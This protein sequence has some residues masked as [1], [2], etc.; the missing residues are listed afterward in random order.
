MPLIASALFI[1]VQTS[2][3][4]AACPASAVDLA[5]L[6]INIPCVLYEGLPYTCVMHAASGI[7]GAELAW[8]LDP[9]LVKPSACAA[10]TASCA[11]ISNTLGLTLKQMN[12]GGTAYILE[13]VYTRH[14]DDP[15]GL[16]WKYLSHQPVSGTQAINLRVSYY[17]TY[18]NTL[19]K[20]AQIEAN[21]RHLS[22][23]IYEA[24]NGVHRLGKITVFS[25][26]G[27]ADDTDILWLKDIN[28][29][30]QP[31]WFNSQLGGYGIKGQR[32]QH[33]DIGANN[34]SRYD[35]LKAPRAGG[36]TL[37][38]EWGH[39]FYGLYDE[40][41][42]QSFCSS[43][44]PFA[45]CSGDTPA[46][47]SIMN[48]QWNAINTADD[49]LADARWLNFSTVQ[50]GSTGNANYRMYGTNGWDTLIRTPDQ[51]PPHPGNKR[52][53]YPELLSKAPPSGQAPSVELDTPE[54]IAAAALDL[55]VVF[56]PG[57]SLP[58]TPR[59]S[60]NQPVEWIG[61]VKQIVLDR[62]AA[63]TSQ[64]LHHVKAAAQSIIDESEIGDVIGVIVADTT[65]TVVH[66]PTLID[67]EAARDALILAVENI[68]P[69]SGEPMI[70]QA[71]NAAL[72]GMLG[73]EYFER[74]A[75][76][77][78]LFTHGTQAGN[79]IPVIEAAADLS[80][81]D[82][83][84]FIL[85]ITKD[86]AT[87]RTLLKA[88]EITG[89]E[90][91]R[92]TTPRRLQ[93]ALETMHQLSSPAIDVTVA[94]SY[95]QFE[96]SAE[97]KFYLDESLGEVEIS[98]EFHGSLGSLDVALVDPQGAVH[99]FTSD[100][101][102]DVLQEAETGAEHYNFCTKE[103]RHPLAGHWTLQVQHIHGGQGAVAVTVSALPKDNAH[104]FFAAIRTEEPEPFS[105]GEIV[106]VLATLNADLPITGLSV[107]GLVE[108]EDEQFMPVLMRDDG[109]SPDRIAEDGL[110]TGVFTPMETG[111]Y[112]LFADFDNTA[113]TAHYSDLGILYAPDQDG[114]IP[115]QQLTHIGQPFQR[116]AMTK[117]WVI[118]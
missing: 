104:S 107:T 44:R 83:M 42:G 29:S 106:T 81:H 33:C 53:Y 95:L 92:A 59:Q 48:T 49:S 31:C 93:Q 10:E 17:D 114:S 101:C 4:A 98:V 68:T 46:D 72:Q 88:A 94:H 52:T 47:I 65:V 84:L 103:E 1:N 43:S 32:V 9:A 24:S 87:N 35:M 34:P 11:V 38:H 110:Y 91:Y 40:Y 41:K 79:D 105:V 16:Y 26:G 30:N 70:G 18:D 117:A 75:H 77:V 2:W 73:S 63:M 28:D 3:A 116:F 55:Q 57:G 25:D 113:N 115:E 6:Q 20:K 118:E 50:S 71:L 27:H 19:T 45:P 7:P 96:H 56:K 21:F 37:G 67:S 69:G 22:E 23:A 99:P 36:Y 15:S 8:R 89:G 60:Q 108:T 86:V 102:K 39:F 111:K 64:Q 66:T 13:L 97:M 54:G 112:L 78:Y 58:A 12:I 100:H 109:V 62:S 85:G 61:T 5:T 82:V 76:S 90:F 74:H 51:D 14:P 80:R